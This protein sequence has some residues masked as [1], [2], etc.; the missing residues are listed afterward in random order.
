[1]Y[2]ISILQK[3]IMFLR[4]ELWRLMFFFFLKYETET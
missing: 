3:N 1:M 4:W 2:K